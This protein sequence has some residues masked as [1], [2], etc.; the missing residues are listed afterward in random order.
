MWS[1]SLAFIINYLIVAIRTLLACLILPSYREL[2]HHSSHDDL[3]VLETYLAGRRGLEVDLSSQVLM[4]DI[5][6]VAHIDFEDVLVVD[7]VGGLVA[8]KD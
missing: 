3:V 7:F 4:A 1:E 8:N 5:A 2:S 6:V